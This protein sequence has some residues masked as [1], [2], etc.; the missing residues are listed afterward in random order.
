ML[1][2]IGGWL[3]GEEVWAGRQ[4]ES[5]PAF[6]CRLCRIDKKVDDIFPLGEGEAQE[7]LIGAVFEETAHEIGHPGHDLSAGAVQPHPAGYPREDP[8]DRFSHPVEHLKLIATVRY[9]QRSGRLHHGRDGT[10]IVGCAGKIGGRV[11]KY[12]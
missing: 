7:T 12:T 1:A 6:C 9:A 4:N 10:Y 5:G 11:G 3:I 8:L 2:E